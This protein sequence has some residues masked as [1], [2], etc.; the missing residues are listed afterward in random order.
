MARI[1]SLKPQFFKNE[2][3]TALSP[4]HRLAYQGLWCYADRD[5]RLRDRPRLLKVEIFPFDDLDMDA[6]LWD[7][8]DAGFILRYSVDEKDFISIPTFADHQVPK[9]D[10]HSSMC[11]A[12][13]DIEKQQRH[14]S[15]TVVVPRVGHKDIGTVGHEEGGA[16]G[17]SAPVA[18]K[19]DPKAEELVELW[20]TETCA[21]IPRCRELSPLRRTRATVRL[22]ERPLEEWRTVIRAIQASAFCRGVNDRGWKATFDWLVQSQETAIRVLEGKYEGKAAGDDITRDDYAKAE[23]YRQ[24]N[25]GRCP[26]DPKCE[27]YAECINAIALDLRTQGAA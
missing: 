6:I 25:Y 8:Q 22:R 18:P 9:K 13:S 3:L 1:R 17:A 16:D 26:H 14:R 7:L 20:N 12:C 15:G 10:E 21:P 19:V 23:K 4:W 11:P 5:G 2:E 27:N 24:A